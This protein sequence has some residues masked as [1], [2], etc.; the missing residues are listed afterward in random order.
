MR[1]GALAASRM[2]IDI[3]RPEF[4][5]AILAAPTC[6]ERLFALIEHA[7]REDGALVTGMIDEGESIRVFCELRDFSFSAALA[8]SEW[9]QLKAMI[10]IVRSVAGAG[11]S[12]VEMTFVSSREPPVEA[13]EAYPDTKIMLS[14]PHTSILVPRLLMGVPCPKDLS[15]GEPTPHNGH[16][17]FASA[18]MVREIVTPYLRD[19]PLSL[20]DVAEM[21]GTS[22]RSL[23]RHFRDLGL[24]F[25]RL[26][27]DARYG[28]ARDLLAS[29]DCRVVE[30]AFA[31]GY[32]NPSHFTRAF[33]R[34]AGITP[35]EFRRSIELAS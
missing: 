31:A 27:A 22:P 4:R 10:E 18:D 29:S 26:V 13:R 19:K 11:W 16:E 33:R 24:S 25:T 12:P 14:C 20:G 6:G 15:S 23:Q 2:S 9:L 28:V 21:L 7:P 5:N 17:W 3:L 32:E 8:Y 1:Y 35:Q 30:V 34:M